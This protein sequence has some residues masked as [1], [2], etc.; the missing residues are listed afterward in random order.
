MDIFCIAILIG[1]VVRLVCK[2]GIYLYLRTNKSEEEIRS[3]KGFQTLI[4][5]YVFNKILLLIHI[6]IYAAL[7]VRT[8]L[9]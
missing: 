6:T 9:L 4:F 2:F 5:M 3:K 7:A 1:L 8:Y